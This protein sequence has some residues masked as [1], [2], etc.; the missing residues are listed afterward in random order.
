[1]RVGIETW[2]SDGD[3]RPLIALGGGLAARGHEVTLAA[4][5]V[6]DK[7]YG[8]L[9]AALGIEY[10][11]VVERVNLDFVHF[12]ERFLK[13]KSTMKVMSELL[14]ATFYPH[15][16]RMSQIARTLAG[17]SDVVIGHFFMFPLKAA[18]AKTGV[19]YASVTLWPAAVPSAYRPPFR[20]PNLGRALN[21]FQWKFAEWVLD[22]AL[23]KRVTT[24]WENEGL[25]PPKHALGGA[26]ASD[27]LNLIA[28]SSIFCNGYPDW[29]TRHRVVGFLN[30]PEAS[31]NWSPSPMLVKF[32][33]EDEPPVYMTL[34]SSGQIVPEEGMELMIS[35]A[36]IA[37]CRAVVQTMSAK[38]LPGTQRGTAY[39]IG[40]APHAQVF[41]RCAAVVHHGGAGTTH[42]VAR[43]G[44]PSAIVA[45]SDEQLF[46][47]GELRRLG[48]A[49]APIPFRKATSE[50]LARAIRFA[51]DSPDAG[52]RAEEV[53]ER[54]RR[55]DGVA[56]A[57]QLVEEL[58]GTARAAGSGERSS[59][60]G[61]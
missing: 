21:R 58:A 3:I 30:V 32:L 34:G 26:L 40:R 31:E 23:R 61:Q 13:T 46:W 15:L 1:M 50:K 19:P 56:T 25:S 41:P 35:A 54:M 27:T 11:K 12:R 44:R 16:D 5:S 38:Y 45:F 49:S 2:G 24:A 4:T 9:C 59:R 6:D 55:E 47:G 29:G 8:A 48:I 14:D 33:Q 28:A 57:V 43:C 7:D 60:S 51:L 17:S 36:E 10:I 37:G 22:R 42:T 39:F 52:R 18:A 20:F 53:A